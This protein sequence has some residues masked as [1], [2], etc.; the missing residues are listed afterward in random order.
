M[1]REIK[2]I[3]MKAYLKPMWYTFVGLF[4]V[5]ASKILYKMARGEKLNLKNPKLYDEKLQ[6]LKLFV[7]SKNDLVSQCADK[8]SV[9][10]FIQQCGLGHTLNELIGVW[11]NVDD[12]PFEQLPDKFVL[13]CTHGCHMNIICTDK[14]NLDIA[15]TKKQ[16]K[17]WMKEKYWKRS[18]ELHYAKIKPRVICEKYMSELDTDLP[19]DYKIYCMNGEP[20]F[21]EIISGRSSDFLQ[22]KDTYRWIDSWEPIDA[23]TVENDPSILRPDNFDEMVSIS[24]KLAQTG[25]FPCVRVDLYNIKGKIIFGELTF[26]SA[27]CA[28]ETLYRSIEEMF[29]D[30]LKIDSIS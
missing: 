22:Y 18:A 4:P 27:G 29:G 25:N 19:I 23:T 21:V 14:G 2:L 9:R 11:D 24:R 10:E 5:T 30:M 12:I 7:Y 20:Q 6:Y 28:D 16:L 3:F 13:K 8:Y 26:T 17:R 15:K 1:R